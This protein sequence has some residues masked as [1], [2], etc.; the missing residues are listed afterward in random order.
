[1]RLWGIDPKVMCRK[2]LLGEHVEMHMIVGSLRRR[3][4]LGRLLT[5]GFVDLRK[6]AA[7]HESLAYE[8]KRRGYR[9]H[10]HFRSF[11][12]PWEADACWMDR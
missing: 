9:H 4:N 3:R 1:M 2:H 10:R 6:V 5:A 12:L 8:M 7:R 11:R